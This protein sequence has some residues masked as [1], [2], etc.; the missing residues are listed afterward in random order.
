MRQLT[1]RYLFFTLLL[2]SFL[3][4]SQ[5]NCVEFND[6][7]GCAPY[8]VSI[9]Y[10]GPVKDDGGPFP[11][12][13]E[14]E[15]GVTSTFE[16]HTYTEAGIYNLR[17]FITI[18]EGPNAGDYD[19]TFRDVFRIVSNPNI[20]FELTPCHNKLL[21]VAID[22]SSYDFYSITNNINSNTDTL[23]GFGDISLDFSGFTNSEV[24]I[25][26]VG[27]YDNA[28]CSATATATSQLIENMLPLSVLELNEYETPDASFT[29]S[30]P[31]NHK[32]SLFS[33]TNEVASKTWINSTVTS[34]FEEDIPEYES[35]KFT[36]A[37]ACGTQLDILETPTFKSETSFENNENVISHTSPIFTPTFIDYLKDTSEGFEIIT[38]RDTDIICNDTNCYFL[39]TQQSINGYSF[40]HFSTGVCGR[41]FSSDVPSHPKTYTLNN[42]ITDSIIINGFQGNPIKELEINNENYNALSNE[43]ITL[44]YE[45]GCFT[46]RFLNKCDVW[47]TDTTLCPLILSRP[48]SSNLVWNSNDN[49]E[50]SVQWKNSSNAGGTLFFNSISGQTF[51]TSDY[52]AQE[53][54]LYI[55]SSPSNS[56]SNELCFESETFL[57]IPDITTNGEELNLKNKFITSFNMKILDLNG[58]LLLEL[59]EDNKTISGVKPD[60]YFY[61]LQ[62]ISEAGDEIEKK[63]TLII[64]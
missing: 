29:P 3:A 40:D 46:L 23:R 39:K 44:P 16:T 14:Y 57:F 6:T 36:V 28:P 22:S 18:S 41:S 37:D 38:D 7:V 48:N 53:F 34:S 24:E 2:G 62:G 5:V 63:G 60:T 13:Y 20:K 10:C 25:T 55:L 19:S 52:P 59:T 26:I 11:L 51:S 21:N 54:C 47:S 8:T 1:H 64:K 12:F 4:N 58:N 32:L 45:N 61:I 50:Y 56:V 43:L 9:Q 17:Q 42:S 15:K 49:E 31:F 27:Q 33:E 35:I 30:G